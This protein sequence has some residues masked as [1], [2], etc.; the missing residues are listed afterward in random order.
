MSAD[1][2]MSKLTQDRSAKCANTDTGMGK[3]TWAWIRGIAC[4][5]VIVVGYAIDVA[6]HLGVLVFLVL[7]LLMWLAPK[8]NGKPAGLNIWGWL[9][10][11]VVGGAIAAIPLLERV[12]GM[13]R[14]ILGGVFLFVLW[15]VPVL[16]VR[17][18]VWL[19]PKRNGRPAG[20]S[21]GGWLAMAVF[22]LVCQACTVGSHL[23][24][25]QIEH[26]E[27]SDFELPPPPRF[28]QRAHGFTFESP[29]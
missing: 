17:L 20:L 8:R 23:A 9:A 4:V 27:P 3:K 28:Y 24:D 22:A 29:L 25:R 7:L 12:P 18:P 10:A 5:S 2:D 16:I 26:E 21:K 11:S 13:A 6:W 19:A 14:A 1:T 15:L